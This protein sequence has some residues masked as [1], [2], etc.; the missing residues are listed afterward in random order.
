MQYKGEVK[1]QVL[2]VQLDSEKVG[3]KLELVMPTTETFGTL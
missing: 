3:R 1:Y 2:P